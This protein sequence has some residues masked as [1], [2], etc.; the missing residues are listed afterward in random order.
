MAHASSYFNSAGEI[1]WSALFGNEVEDLE[2]LDAQ[3]AEELQ[4]QEAILLSAEETILY[5]SSASRVT[6]T[7]ASSW[8]PKQ[9]QEVLQEKPV[10]PPEPTVR[11]VLIEKKGIKCSQSRVA[12]THFVLIALTHTPRLPKEAIDRWEDLLCEELLCATG[13]RLY[14]PFKD[15]SALLLNDNQGEAMAETECPN[16]HRLFCVQ[17][18]VP[19]HPGISCEEYQTLSED[20]RGRDDLMVRN[21]AKE[22]K[23]RNCPSCRFMVER[24]E[25]C[26]HMTC[27]CRYQ[28]CY[29]CG[30]KWTHDH[31]GCQGN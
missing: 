2:D 22:K 21:L 1:Y 30:A 7:R 15:C 4:F 20:E 28:F 12:L 27:R 9:G 26:P 10:N 6:D 8:L 23:W 14:C 24:T 13:E 29:A 31:G 11:F 18:N 16:C 19:W 25:G 5:S 3:L 17:C